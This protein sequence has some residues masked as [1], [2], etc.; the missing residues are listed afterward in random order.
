MSDYISRDAAENIFACGKENWKDFEAAACIAALPAADVREVVLC[1]NCANGEWENQNHTY[2]W[3]NLWNE[4][5]ENWWF[6]ASGIKR[7]ADMR[8]GD[9]E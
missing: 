4:W 9:A 1:R 5:K 6:C 8:G 7:G 3:C 2:A